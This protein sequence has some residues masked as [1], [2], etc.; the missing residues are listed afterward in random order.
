MTCI[1]LCYHGH[2]TGTPPTLTKLWFL[3]ILILMDDI[4]WYYGQEH[5]QEV[6][7]ELTNSVLL[8]PVKFFWNFGVP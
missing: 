7:Y 4:I 2:P 1:H 3:V 6:I 5:G 8:S